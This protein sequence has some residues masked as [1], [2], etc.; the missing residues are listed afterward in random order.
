[1]TGFFVSKLIP[2]AG[3]L[4]KLGV[5][6]NVAVREAEMA[7]PE[8][9]Y[10]DPQDHPVEVLT[11]YNVTGDNENQILHI[12][13][14]GKPEELNVS[15]YTSN[16]KYLESGTTFIHIDTCGLSKIG[17]IQTSFGEG[18]TNA[19][20]QWIMQAKG[21][22]NITPNTVIHN[23]YD[24]NISFLINA[25]E[26]KDMKLEG[27][28]VHFSLHLP[29]IHLYSECGWDAVNFHFYLAK[30]KQHVSVVIESTVES[31][32]TMEEEKSI[33]ESY[34]KTLEELFVEYNL[35]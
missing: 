33:T 9:F 2:V 12:F 31:A 17:E 29:T 14:K 22:F 27:M 3:E 13:F 28:S 4:L 20:E 1:M 35:I 15:A 7:T 5:F 6:T 10:K 18:L 11:F 23:L 16:Y 26:H 30:D 8:V 21:I 32:E 24:E 19:I 34:T 25:Y